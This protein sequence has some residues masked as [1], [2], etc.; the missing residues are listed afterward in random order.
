VGTNNRLSVFLKSTSGLLSWGP[1][2]WVHLALMTSVV[3]MIPQMLSD[4]TCAHD[5]VHDQDTAYSRVFF[6]FLLLSIALRPRKDPARQGSPASQGPLLSTDKS[7]AGKEH[8]ELRK[9]ALLIT[10]VPQ[11]CL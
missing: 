9:S 11:P 3:I 5:L 4:C 8:A 6:R 1:F 10:Q 2:V 7:Q